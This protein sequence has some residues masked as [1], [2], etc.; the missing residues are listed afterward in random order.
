M[1]PR[2]RIAFLTGSLFMAGTFFEI[3]VPFSEVLSN[4]GTDILPGVA[5]AFS[6]PLFVPQKNK[7]VVVPSKTNGE[8]IELPNFKELFTRIEQVSPLAEVALQGRDGGFLVMDDN[9]HPE[10]SWKTIESNPQKTVHSIQKIDNFQN[11]GPPILRFRASLKGPG[12]TCGDRFA[13][14]IM[15]RRARAHWDPQIDQVYE[16]HPVSDLKRVTEAQRR[17]YGGEGGGDV[18]ECTLCGVGYTLL[19]PS[20]GVDA[21]EQLTLCGIQDLGRGCDSDGGATLIWGVELEE[22][23][24]YLMPPLEE[25][26]HARAREGVRPTRAK[27]CLFSTAVVPTGDDEFDVE[28]CLQFDAGGKVPLWL[29]TPVLIN[30]VKA[31]FEYAKEY[32]GSV[33]TGGELDE[34]IMAKKKMKEA[35]DVLVTK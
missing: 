34:Y 24:N 18:G 29:S 13:H 20:W 27:S 25:G 16:I 22:R 19:H 35:G 11:L 8:S 26:V 4:T 9:S 30:K 10:L 7:P 6:G 5:A 28:Y 17:D 23:H 32:Y 14:F 12:R 1:T 2:L 31:M 21:R 33:G 15:N 3:L